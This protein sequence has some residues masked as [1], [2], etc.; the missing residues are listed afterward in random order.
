MAYSQA[1][2]SNFRTAIAT[3]FDI[4]KQNSPQVI[5]HKIMDFHNTLSSFCRYLAN[6][7]YAR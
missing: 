7:Q 5:P 2:K 1:A 6:S 4:E 3:G